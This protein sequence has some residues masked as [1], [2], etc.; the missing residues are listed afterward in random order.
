[1]TYPVIGNQLRTV[2]LESKR[3]DFFSSLVIPDTVTD[4]NQRY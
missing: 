1:M 2:F 3:P 4:G